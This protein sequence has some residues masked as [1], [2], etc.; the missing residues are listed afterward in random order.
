MLV[1]FGCTAE[2]KITQCNRLAEVI[3]RLRAVQPPQTPEDLTVLAT[4]FEGLR[5]ELRAIAIQDTKL[6]TL[7]EQM[8]T[9]YTDV[10]VTLRLRLKSTAA[11]NAEEVQKATA[12]LERLVAEEEKFVTAMNQFCQ[13]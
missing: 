3:N 9:L 2:S 7:Q 13:E 10:V 11:N 8:V 6:K 5:K 1:L 12:E 4:T